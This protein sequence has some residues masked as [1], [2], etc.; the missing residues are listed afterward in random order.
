MRLLMGEGGGEE[1][2]EEQGVREE[3]SLSARVLCVCVCV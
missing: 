1:G 2:G 3:G